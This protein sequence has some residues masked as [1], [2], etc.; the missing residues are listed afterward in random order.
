YWTYRGK[1]AGRQA[2]CAAGGPCPKEIICNLRAG[3]S[4]DAC[5]GV[6]FS[7][8]RSDEAE[9]SDATG[10]HSLYKRA[11]PKPWNKK[12]CGLTPEL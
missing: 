9:A 5:S 2:A 6:H 12:L 3:R 8:K 10:L 11:D 4:S 1:S 7:L